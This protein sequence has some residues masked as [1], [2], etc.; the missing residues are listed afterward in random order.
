MNPDRLTR[1]LE[2][3]EQDPDDAFTQFAIA[4]EYVKRSEPERALSFFETLVEGQPA[5]TGTY[6][7]LGKLYEQLG[8]RDDAVATYRK[9]IEV[10]RERRQL[11]DLSELQDA[12]VQA[13]GIG[14]DEEFE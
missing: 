6:Y 10:S 7:H 14:F 12:L 8:R 5:Y 4:R 1:L 11:K 13:Q 3:Y 2:F 9:G